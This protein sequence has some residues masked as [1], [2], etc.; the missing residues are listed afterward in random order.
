MTR[1]VLDA[2]PVEH[3]APHAHHARIEWLAAA[4]FT[5]PAAWFLQLCAVYALGS[6]ACYPRAAPLQAALPGWEWTWGASLAINLAT[7]VLAVA[8]TAFSYWIWR[9]TR[10]ESEGGHHHA[11]E[12]GEGRTRFLAVFGLWSGVWFALAI[13]FDTIALMG[14]PL[15]GS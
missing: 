2:Y 1:S 8:A 5:A 7:L 13:L 14:V 10:G 11:V 3:P 6:H 15:C 4:L 9:Q 12:A